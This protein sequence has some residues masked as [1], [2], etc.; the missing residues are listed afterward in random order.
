[1][2]KIV[3]A[4]FAPGVFDGHVSLFLVFPTISTHT[5][6][7]VIDM[8]CRE[9]FGQVYGRDVLLLQAEGA[10]THRAEGMYM[11]TVVVIAVFVVI[12]A[13]TILP[14]SAAVLESVQQ[15]VFFKKGKGAE[16]AATIYCGQQDFHIGQ[17]EGMT[18]GLYFAPNQLAHRCRTD[19]V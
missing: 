10:V 4:L 8:L 3:G 19:V 12:Q 14:V 18:N 7:H 9:S 17:R 5:L 13:E 11:M 6:H 2:G 1:M 15:V 16:D